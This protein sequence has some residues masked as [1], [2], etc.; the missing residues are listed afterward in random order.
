MKRII[1]RIVI[2]LIWV[3]FFRTMQTW[4]PTIYKDIKHDKTQLLDSIKGLKEATRFE[5]II[6][7]SDSIIAKSIKMISNKINEI[8]YDYYY[9]TDYCIDHFQKDRMLSSMT[10]NE[11]YE[12]KQDINSWDIMKWASCTLWP[13][14]SQGYRTETLEGIEKE[15]LKE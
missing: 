9:I 15:V 7:V 4:E 5:R 11:W 10:L 2:I 12:F 14:T 8:H 6:A 13:Y 3:S 1:I